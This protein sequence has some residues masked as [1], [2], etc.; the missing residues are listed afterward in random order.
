MKFEGL[1]LHEPASWHSNVATGMTGLMWFWVFLRWSKDGE[2]LLVRCPAPIDAAPPPAGRPLRTV[3]SSG[4]VP[5]FLLGS[6]VEPLL[7]FCPFLCSSGTHRTLSTTT[8]MVT[9]TGVGARCSIS[10]GSSTEGQLSQII[11]A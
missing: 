8:I 10:Q 2:T 3:S 5:F 1:T 9:R 4:G 11:W 7:A 6:T